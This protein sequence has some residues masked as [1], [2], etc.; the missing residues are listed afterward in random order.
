MLCRYHN[1]SDTQYLL[2]DFNDSSKYYT[3][4]WFRDNA[5]NPCMESTYNFVSKVIEEVQALHEVNLL[6]I[7]FFFHN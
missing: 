5:I 7:F 3:V 6:F 1:M 4:Q 2:T